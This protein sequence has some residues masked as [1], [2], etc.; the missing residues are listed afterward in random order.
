MNSHFWNY[1]FNLIWN[2]LLYND[3]FDDGILTAYEVMNMNLDSTE[4]VVLSACETGLGQITDGEGVY[5][6]QRAFHLAGAEY[7]MM[8]LWKVEDLATQKLMQLF[9][10]YWLNGLS[11]YDALKEAQKSLRMNQ[12]YN[13][14]FYW[15]AFILIR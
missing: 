4:L 9:Y 14:P 13:H 11:K 8:S 7:V 1:I 10:I 15:G 3:N 5:G 6:L 12:N 2:A